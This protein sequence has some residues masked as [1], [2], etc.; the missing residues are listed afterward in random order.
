MGK[1]YRR[2]RNVWDDD[3]DRFDRRSK[4]RKTSYRMKEDVYQERRRLKNKNREQHD[5]YGYER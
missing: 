1:T 2:E 3:S 5:E 4:K